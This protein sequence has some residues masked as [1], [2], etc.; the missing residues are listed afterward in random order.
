MTKRTLKRIIGFGYLILVGGIYLMV[1]D[2]GKLRLPKL[3]ACFNWALFGITCRALIYYQLKRTG[4]D[5]V[6]KEN[7]AVNTIVA[8][9]FYGVTSLAVVSIIYLTFFNTLERLDLTYF[10]WIVIPL[11][12]YI[13]FAINEVKKRF[14]GG[15]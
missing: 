9:F 14:L 8:Y 1:S 2:W 10:D 13:G 3:F 15:D 4:Q 5:D 12:S 11:F 7:E 6:L